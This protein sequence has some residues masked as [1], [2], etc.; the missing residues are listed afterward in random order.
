MEHGIHTLAYGQK[1]ITAKVVRI[2]SGKEIFITSADEGQSKGLHLA[3]PV[4]PNM[5]QAR[6][7]NRSV[8]QGRRKD[9]FP[10]DRKRLKEG[11]AAVHRDAAD[12]VSEEFR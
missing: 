5:I 8:W 9:A 11:L 1:D 10:R 4:D 6:A 2:W 12:D 7:L 3:H